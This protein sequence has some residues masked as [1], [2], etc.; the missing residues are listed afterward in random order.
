MSDASKKHRDFLL[1]T[2]TEVQHQLTTPNAL[3]SFVE[4][5][6]AKAA[7]VGSTVGDDEGSDG[8]FVE[9][10]EEDEDIEGGDGVGGTGDGMARLGSRLGATAR[11]SV[12]APAWFISVHRAWRRC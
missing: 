12:R 2:L 10:D 3:K 7:P 5:H 9:D 8:D 6:A 4:S 11:L 1:S